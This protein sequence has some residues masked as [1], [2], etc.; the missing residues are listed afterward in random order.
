M[1]S[2]DVESLFTNI[3]LDETINICANRIYHKRKKVKG[4]LKRQFKQLLTFATKSSCFIFNGVYH[5]QIDGVAMCSPLGPTLTNLFLVHYAKW[6]RDCPIKFK[7]SYF[8]RYVDDIFLLFEHRDQKFLRYMNSRHKNIKFTFEEEEN[9]S[10]SF[11]DVKITRK[12]GKFSTSIHRLSVEY[13]WI[14]KALCQW[15]TKKV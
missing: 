5:S 13:I 9:G 8:W 1:V 4:L 12:N 7:P 3:P 6:L 2:F 11:L 14:L 10:L 15:N